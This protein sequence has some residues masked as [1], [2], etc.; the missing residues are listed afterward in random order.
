MA[1][2][3][4]RDISVAVYMQLLHKFAER[5]LRDTAAPH[6]CNHGSGRER[7]MPHQ[8]SLSFQSFEEQ[9]IQM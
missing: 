5:Q 2:A 8:S 7:C 3:V 9:N 6:Q 4:T 1:V